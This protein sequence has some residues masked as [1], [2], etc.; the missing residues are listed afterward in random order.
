VTHRLTPPGSATQPSHLKCDLLAFQAFAFEFCLRRYA[1]GV[2]SNREHANRVL[3]KAGAK[4]WLGVRPTT[5]GV[6]MNPVD[7]PHGG[8][9]GRTSGGR[10]SCTPWWGWLYTLTFA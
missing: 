2:L 10:P 8:G 7:H 1:E 5:R 4:R 6:A 9:E 3:G